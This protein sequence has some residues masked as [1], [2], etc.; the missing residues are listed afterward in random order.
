MVNLHSSMHTAITL[1]KSGFLL[2]GKL[3][4][5]IIDSGSIAFHDF[6]W[7]MLTIFLVDE[8]LLTIYVKWST[9]FRDSLGIHVETNTSCCLLSAG[10][11]L[12]RVYFQEALGH[13]RC[14]RLS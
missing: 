9:N 11:K 13:L 8:M 14:L 10:I 2:S 4:F 6:A 3:D 1:K 5:N 12:G 7:R